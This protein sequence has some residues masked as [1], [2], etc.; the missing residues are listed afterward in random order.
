LKE[1]KESGETDLEKQSRKLKKRSWG[2]KKGKII[3][4]LATQH[5]DTKKGKN[6]NGEGATQTMRR[7]NV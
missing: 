1:G 2:K 7:Q 4:R 3:G 5:N 6:T